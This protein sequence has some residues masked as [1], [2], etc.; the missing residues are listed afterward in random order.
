ML[1]I[2]PSF[3]RQQKLKFHKLNV[4]K[5]VKNT[6]KPICSDKTDFFSFYWFMEFPFLSSQKTKLNEMISSFFFCNFVTIFYCL[7]KKSSTCDGNGHFKGEHS[8]NS[9]KIRNE[10]C[11]SNEKSFIQQKISKSSPGT[12]QTKFK[13]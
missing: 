8:I 11:G 4:K 2:K 5:V 6:K 12:L 10:N 1:R 7:T 3:S 9:F 13:Q